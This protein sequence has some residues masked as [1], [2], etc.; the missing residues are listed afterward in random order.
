[1]NL[2]ENLRTE[3]DVVC[4]VDDRTPLPRLPRP[5]PEGP[6]VAPTDRHAAPV[7]RALRSGIEL[8]AGQIAARIGAHEE[9]V[10]RALIVLRLACLV[11]KLRNPARW[12][13]VS[14]N[15]EGWV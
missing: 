10:D 7:M 15:D 9:D 6:T 1:M 8:E 12:K 11:V 2:S 4:P 5:L 3:I 13:S 14:T